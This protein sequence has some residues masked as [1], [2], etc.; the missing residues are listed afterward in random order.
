MRLLLLAG[1]CA[2][3]VECGELRK[4]ELQAAYESA[5]RGFEGRVGICAQDARGVACV[6]GSQRFSLQSVI[7][8]LAGVATL[9]AVDRR[10]WH[11]D[12]TIV[13]RKRDLSL[14]VQPIAKLVTKDGYPTS[15]AD[16]IRRATVDSD[17]AAGDILIR[18]LGGPRAVQ[19][20]LDRNRVADV[21]LDRD[22]RDLQTEIVGLKWKAAYLD[23]EVLDHDIAAVPKS[24]RDAAWERY[25][26]DV[27]DTATPL[28]MADFLYRLAGEKLLSPASS[29]FMFRVMTETLTAPDRLK[30]GVPAGWTLGHKTGTSGGW[31]GR[32]VA[33]NDVGILK[34]PDGTMISI[35]VFVGDSRATGEAR[36]ALIAKLAA[37]TVEHYVP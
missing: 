1:L 30:A 20:Y 22:E 4:T 5:L 15:L 36:A 3:S 27:R 31:N 25:L 33:T 16:L 21:R 26:K 13:V 29:R 17:S 34:A 8:M 35:A 6:N 37:L 28:G 24:R 11:L 32:T 19:A 7:K 23:P 12:E 2:A 18:R 10:G 14:Y 9:D